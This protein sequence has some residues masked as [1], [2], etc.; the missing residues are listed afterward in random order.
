MFK[1]KTYFNR[2]VKSHIERLQEMLQNSRSESERNSH[3]NAIEHYMK[4]YSEALGI[5]QEELKGML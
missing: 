3:M 1:D 5:T 2:V 4:V